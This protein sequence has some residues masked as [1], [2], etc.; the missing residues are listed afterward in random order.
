M[1][2]MQRQGLDIDEI[3]AAL[4]L[5]RS[6]VEVLLRPLITSRRRR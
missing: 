6:T 2:E 1:R 4:G 5:T 3:A